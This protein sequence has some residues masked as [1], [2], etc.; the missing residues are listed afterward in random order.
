MET[1]IELTKEEI[2]AIF[3]LWN[4]SFIEQGNKY[5]CPKAEDSIEQAEYFLELAYRLKK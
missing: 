3:M 1:K 4:T 5:E 2:T